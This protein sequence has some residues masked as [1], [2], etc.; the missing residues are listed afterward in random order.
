MANRGKGGIFGLIATFGIALIIGGGLLSVAKMNNIN[1]I[2]DL[3][4]Y[5]K[6]HSDGVKKCYDNNGQGCVTLPSID[7][8]SKPEPNEFK[9]TDKDLD[10]SGPKKGISYLQETAKV[11][12]DR[13][14][15]NL[16]KL[17]IGV[18]EK[19]KF[20]EKDW[21]HWSLESKDNYC[22]TTKSEV[23]YSQ[24]I[25]DTISLVDSNH[26][27]TK[28]K[29]KA[30]AINK[31]KWTDPYSGDLIS[32]PSEMTIDYIIPLSVANSIGG[33]KWTPEQKA[34]YA[35]DTKNTMI[36]VSKDSKTDRKDADIDKFKLKNDKYKCEF[37]KSYTAIATKYNLSPT[38]KTKDVI[39]KI[40]TSC[41][42]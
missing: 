20:N 39:G 33:Y 26:N 5:S 2:S 35:N 17:K 34:Q 19:V 6:R 15:D 16:D 30:C 42:K 28:D 10:Y 29:A 9:L 40:I 18:V 3:Y 22:W 23:L 25:T 38:Q 31:G 4:N 12:K 13:V 1:S 36:A 7:Q 11:K 8:N 24:S 14:L 32:N 27:S 41:S 21:R 37:A